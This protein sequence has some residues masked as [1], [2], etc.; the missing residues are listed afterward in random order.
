MKN[1]C[2]AFVGILVLIS[3]SK[4]DHP[5][6]S[7]VTRNEYKRLLLFKSSEFVAFKQISEG[8][9]VQ[10]MPMG[11][12]KNYFGERVELARPS[13]LLFYGD[14]LTITRIDGSE[15][16]L[17][18][19]ENDRLYAYQENRN[20]WQYLGLRRGAKAFLLHSGFYIKRTYNEQRLLTTMGWGYDLESYLPLLEK[21]Q[22]SESSLLWLSV[23][24]LYENVEPPKNQHNEHENHPLLPT[25][26][27]RN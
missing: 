12:V 21:E 5:I 6:R 17:V 24:H 18:K 26:P 3:C 11:E 16:Y 7:N 8:N 4:E 15:T 2:I 22:N 1:I 27:S 13:K 23:Y 14:S 20:T 9:V 25:L 10:D 19:W